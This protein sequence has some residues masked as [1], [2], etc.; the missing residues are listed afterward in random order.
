VPGCFERS[1]AII[2]MMVPQ[3]RL[4]SGLVLAGG[5]SSRMGR[6]KALIDF[7]GQPLV[8]RVADR[9]ARAAHPVLLAT[10]SLGR[11]GP[12]GYREVADVSGECG[13]L[14][15]LLA[16]LE[17]SPHELVAVV[18]ADMPYV[19]PELLK[20][21][22]SLSQGEDAVVPMGATGLEPLHAVYSTSALPAM[23]KALAD[24]HYGLRQLLSDLRVREVRAFEWSPS[25]IDPRFAFNIN[26]PE[27]LDAEV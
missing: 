15:G 3:A 17:A 14:G 11:L 24:G 5:R 9:L 8:L 20:F 7:E 1:P 2:V 19:S 23:R 12:V 27:D 22:A 16:G 4:L 13:P 10:G 6:D 26:T 25:A 18:A 21:L